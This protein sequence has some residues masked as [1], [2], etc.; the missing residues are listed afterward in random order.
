MPMTF[1]TN[2][3]NIMHFEITN[4]K[5]LFRCFDEQRTKKKTRQKE[6]GKEEITDFYK[7]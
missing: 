5:A 6:N 3:F 7:C 1:Q 2:D 4:N